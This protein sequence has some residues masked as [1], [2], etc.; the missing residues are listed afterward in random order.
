[1]EY[2]LKKVGEINCYAFYQCCNYVAA[3][4]LEK[5]W[6]RKVLSLNG[7]GERE[8]IFGDFRVNYQSVST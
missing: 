4:S 1:M 2:A 5:R 6:S 8:R 3:D 7:V